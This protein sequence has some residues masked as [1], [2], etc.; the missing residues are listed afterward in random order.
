MG[1][2]E[3][4]YRTDLK[5]KRTR[6]ILPEGARFIDL[7]HL[8]HEDVDVLCILKEKGRKHREWFKRRELLNSVQ[9][10]KSRGFVVSVKS[11]KG[12]Y[13]YDLS[14]YGYYCFEH[15]LM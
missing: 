6:F 1:K 8:N 15:H 2:I 12:R 4:C 5:G 3:E 13:Y 11:A 9:R 14:Q 10:L 7:K